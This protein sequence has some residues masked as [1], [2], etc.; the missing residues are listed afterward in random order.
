MSAT[1]IAASAASC[2]AVVREELGREH[3]RRTYELV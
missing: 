1:K 2:L 3:A